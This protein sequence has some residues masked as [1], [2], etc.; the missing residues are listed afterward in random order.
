MLFRV[1]VALAGCIAFTG[2]LF[3][4]VRCRRGQNRAF[5]CPTRDSVQPVRQPRRHVFSALLQCVRTLLRTS[6]TLLTD[7]VF[8]RRTART[9]AYRW[10]M[11]SLIFTGFMGLLVFHALDDIITI[12]LFSGYEPTLNPWQWLRN[13]GGLMVLAG[14]ALAGA[15]RARMRNRLSG[16]INRKQDWFLLGIIITIVVSGFT[17]EAA[18]IGSPHAFTRMTEDYFFPETEEDIAALMAYWSAKNGVVFSPP[19]STEKTLI[20]RGEALS[21]ESCGYCHSPTSSAVVSRALA[22]TMRPLAPA[23]NATHADTWLWYLHVG[24][25]LLGLACLPW[26]K[27]LHPVATP[28]N[29]L[30]RRKITTQAGD[31]SH[32]VLQDE[33]GF[34]GSAT[35][36]SRLLGLEACTRCGECSLHCSVA[37][38][39]AV[40]G[41]T[42]ILPSEK[43]ISL[44]R[45]VA[46]TLHGEAQTAFAEGSRTCTHCL[47]CTELCPS[48]IN[49]QD[50]WRASEIRLAQQALDGP[51]TTIR[52]CSAAQWATVLREQNGSGSETSRFPR[53]QGTGLA[54]KPESF[55]GCVQCTTCTSVCP[56]V[57]VSDAP[58]NDLDLMPQQIMNLLRMGLKD[59][60]L[61]VRMVWSCTTC[62]KCQEHCPQNIPV[63]DILFELRQLATARLAEKQIT[64]CPLPRIHPTRREN[65]HEDAVKTDPS[66]VTPGASSEPSFNTGSTDTPKGNV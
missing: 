53:Q 33:K 3:R 51:N 23:L 31:D 13:T 59:E 66:H 20:L 47:R 26:G 41:N 48:G 49:L 6:A 40:T 32:S 27:C 24:A 64:A 65:A 57:A 17:L 5:P 19:A 38:V 36:L 2:I 50:L 15:R 29:L 43:L 16:T 58:G 60:A 4:Y 14:L 37:P 35:S 46:G 18:R 39:F 25:C 9:S 22:T 12:P 42:A 62:Y 7:V 34:P 54:D 30:A 8:L 44:R 1:L 45:A 61:G 21:A 10:L 55:W 52:Q 56:V 11:H 63:A 28:L